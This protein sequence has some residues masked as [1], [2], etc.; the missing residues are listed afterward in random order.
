M[1]LLEQSFQSGQRITLDK[2]TAI[3]LYCVPFV[4][5]WLLI[6]YTKEKCTLYQGRIL[7]GIAAGATSQTV[8][9][10]Y[11][12]VKKK[13]TPAGDGGSGR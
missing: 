5:R 2:K 10:S 11:A 12:T 3:L 9:V 4:A 8:P 13:F 7:T 1:V 6:C